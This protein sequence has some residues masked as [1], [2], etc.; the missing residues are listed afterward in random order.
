MDTT[1]PLRRQARRAYEAGRLRKALSVAA[2]SI[3]LL[4]LAVSCGAGAHL[5]CLLEVGLVAAVVALV[6]RGEGFGAGAVPG[7]LAGA[8]PLAGSLG[9]RYSVHGP[10]QHCD[11]CHVPFAACFTATFAGGLLAGAVIAVA[12]ARL[13]PEWRSRAIGSAA[14]VAA[15]AGSLGCAF[16]G[17]T[18]M[19]G[20]WAGVAL[21]GTP[22]LIA[23]AARAPASSPPGA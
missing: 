9:L 23:F 18:G 4:L 20:L 7:L 22:A 13:R 6:W 5:S 8:L 10:A 1:D 15:L 21:V 14:L 3:P 17:L 12:A 11:G 16:F 19:L 2:L